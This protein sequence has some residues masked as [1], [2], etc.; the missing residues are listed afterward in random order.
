MSGESD[1]EKK[2][3]DGIH[4]N[5]C[6]SS[7]ALYIPASAKEGITQFP[8]LYMAEHQPGHS[9]A[10]ELD[11]DLKN[12]EGNPLKFYKKPIVVAGAGGQAEKEPSSLVVGNGFFKG[13][14]PLEMQQK[15][16]ICVCPESEEELYFDIEVVDDILKQKG[17]NALSVS[18]F[19]HTDV[20]GF[21]RTD[22]GLQGCVVSVKDEASLPEHVDYDFV[23]SRK[24]FISSLERSI[25]ALTSENT[26]LRKDMEKL[27]DILD[28]EDQKTEAKTKI[29]SY[30]SLRKEVRSSRES[31]EKKEFGSADLLF[32][33]K[34]YSEAVA[35]LEGIGIS[36]E[37]IDRLFENEV[38]LEKMKKMKKNTETALEFPIPFGKNKMSILI[39][40]DKNLFYVLLGER[41]IKTDQENYETFIADKILS[42][43]AAEFVNN[44]SKLDY[45][46]VQGIAA[47]NDIIEKGKLQSALK[48]LMIRP[49]IVCPQKEY[50]SIVDKVTRKIGDIETKIFSRKK[51]QKEKIT[52]LVVSLQDAK[53][54]DSIIKTGIVAG[55]NAALGISEGITIGTAVSEDTRAESLQ[56]SISALNTTIDSLETQINSPGLNLAADQ[57]ENL[58]RMNLDADGN[59]V[60]SPEELAVLDTNMDNEVSL[61]E[62]QNWMTANPGFREWLQSNYPDTYSDFTE[63]EALESQ[64]INAESQLNE[65]TSQMNSAHA[66]SSANTAASL[67]IAGG[68]AG[69]NLLYT[70]KI[71]NETKNY[72]KAKRSP[73]AD[74]K[75]LAAVKSKSGTS[76]GDFLQSKHIALVKR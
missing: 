62:M 24:E 69:F 70:L 5:I 25:T 47:L 53:R 67:L 51:G 58:I 61:A 7:I 57:V 12:R 31:K 36:E 46:G 4:C 59:G 35:A 66:N 16:V 22:E 9:V 44:I 68:L 2:R 72:L 52:D 60:I 43:Y 21:K 38:E 74:L 8:F 30:M 50:S 34:N 55:A 56:Q 76:F 41:D 64:R 15:K 26:S 63:I 48:K 6:N 54:K 11:A 37:D 45:K 3:V 33:Q 17:T 27:V 20:V 19:G 29:D 14:V 13:Y 28:T 18:H 75:V 73:V 39:N 71:I 23:S 42:V 32:L 1:K 40:R 49:R 65:Q 10:V